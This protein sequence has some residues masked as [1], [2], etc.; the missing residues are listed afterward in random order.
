MNLAPTTIQTASDHIDLII[1]HI[2]QDG[3]AA[4][5]RAP[6]LEC[7]WP[8]FIRT[9]PVPKRLFPYTA[10]NSATT[11]LVNSLPARSPFMYIPLAMRQRMNG[12]LKLGLS[13]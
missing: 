13:V 1:W 2:C 7:G 9:L 6:L 11:C 3:L 5:N 8:F 4:A 10:S 12:V